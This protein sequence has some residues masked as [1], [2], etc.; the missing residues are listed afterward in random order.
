[1]RHC[2][3]RSYTS[4]AARSKPKVVISATN[5]KLCDF[6]QTSDA[7][8][9]VPRRR[10]EAPSK[11]NQPA[12][13]SQTGSKSF[14]S[15]AAPDSFEDDVLFQDISLAQVHEWASQSPTPL[16]LADVFRYGD[17]AADISQR[18][19]NA[20]FLHR[21]L[22]IR[23]SQRVV[24]LLTL[25][26]GLSRA[27]PIRQ[28]VA[29]YMLYLKRLQA[30]P[31]PDSVES[32]EIFTDLLQSL[33][34][35][36]TSVPTSIA[37]GVQAWLSSLPQEDPSLPR[38]VKE[39][40][41]AL[42]CFFTARVGLRFL[43]EHHVLS[44]KRKGFRDLRNITNMFPVDDEEDY[45]GCI[46]SNCNVVQEVRKV[47]D[48]VTK[49]TK[50]FL[51]SSSAL[52]NTPGLDKPEA[53]TL[54]CP[55]IEIVECNKEQRGFTYVPH[56]L[57]Y[58]MTELLK[59]SVRATVRH[60]YRQSYEDGTPDEAS[61][62][63]IRVIIAKGDEDVTIKIADKAGGIPRSR[64]QTIWK[65]AHSTASE[66]GLETSDFGT[67][68]VLGARIR[69]F[70]L[71]LA[72]IYARYFG[73]ELTLKSTEGY[74]VDAYLYL[75]RLGDSCEKLPLRVLHSPGEADSMPRK[76]QE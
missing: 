48:L 35:D 27:E 14:S 19:H 13:I 72:R 76:G 66:S 2:V 68:E 56:H 23:V 62:P 18:L 17:P 36:R 75:P 57:H 9:T 4:S 65:F 67:D 16:R 46:Q 69:G 5:I 30:T 60:H 6:R 22:P 55:E 26:H 52:H 59:N 31:F 7:S 45:R 10:I 1:M 21:E 34:M 11:P 15:L 61:P 42:Y 51:Q 44:C 12:S 50:E 37:R 3:C 63:P 74:G 54:K 41:E 53:E 58:M 8:S 28:V 29:V 33:I 25:P 40:E 39:M 71:P 73:G 70:G 64:M 38:A 32:E 24:D 20:Q 49:Q 47:A 43:T